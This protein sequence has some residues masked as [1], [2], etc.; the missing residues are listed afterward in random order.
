MHYQALFKLIGISSLVEIRNGGSSPPNVI[1]QPIVLKRSRKMTSS[2]DSPATPCPG[3]GTDPTGPDEVFEK[4]GA[5][6]AG[7][8]PSRFT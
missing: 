7:S 6:E 1:M 4:R 2:K 5:G 8:T 3:A